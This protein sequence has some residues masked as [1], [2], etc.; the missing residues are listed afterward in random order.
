LIKLLFVISIFFLSL[1]ARENPFFNPKGETVPVTSNQGTSLS[2][3]K[4]ASL[5]LPSTARVIESVTIKYKNLDGS[6]DSKS[7]SLNNSIDWHLPLFVSQSYQSANDTLSK[8]KKRRQAKSKVISKT[9]DTKLLHL[10]FIS[11]DANAKTLKVST[12]DAMLRN[13]LLV[14]PHRIVFDLKRDIDIRSYSKKSPRGS[15]FTKIRIG[16]HKG[17]YRVVVELDGYYSYKLH[18]TNGKY[19]FELH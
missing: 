17:Y 9:T 3:L 12:K 14:K 7:M 4:Q 18:H 1:N 15:I 16:N 13:F 6:Q 19:I 5:S 11:F 8:T 10:K 2:P